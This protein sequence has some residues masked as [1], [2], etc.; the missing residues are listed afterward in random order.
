MNI[1]RLAFC[2]LVAAFL[3]GYGCPASKPPSDPLA[4]WRTASKDPDQAIEKDYHDY[5]QKLPPNEQGYYLGP[6]LFLKMEQGSTL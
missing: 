6:I 1:P 4:G 3:C 2:F 5:I